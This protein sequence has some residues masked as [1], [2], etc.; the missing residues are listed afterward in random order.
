[1]K[2]AVFTERSVSIGIVFGVFVAA[3]FGL[4]LGTDWGWPQ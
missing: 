2:V 1:M 3:G 4:F